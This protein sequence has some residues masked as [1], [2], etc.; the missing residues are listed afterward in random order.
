M[1]NTLQYK[2]YFT[3]I[4]YSV[5]DKVLHGKIEG[6][7]DLVTFE[8]EDVAEIESE[9]R[10]AVDDYLDY[11]SSIGK[12]PSKTYKGTFNVRITPQLHRELAFEAMKEG[13]SLNQA[14][15]CAIEQY[16]HARIYDTRAS[17]MSINTKLS[18]LTMSVDQIG[19]TWALPTLDPGSM[20]V[21]TVVPVASN[22]ETGE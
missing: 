8:S 5:E 3:N 12:E 13:V 18:E 15:E 17:I 4:S 16:L 9:F 19:Q 1:E 7:D 22:V 11:C 10:A 21:T 2:G 14:V 6:I 20:Y